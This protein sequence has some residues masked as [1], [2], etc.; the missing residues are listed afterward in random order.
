M[1][2]T[3]TV[4]FWRDDKGFGFIVAKPSQ[5]KLF[6]H[7]RD[8][9][10]QD[11]A[12]QAEQKSSSAPSTIKATNSKA[13]N[14][15][16]TKTVTAKDYRPSVGD[17][18]NFQLDSDKQGRSIA[19]PWQPSAACLAQY[20]ANQ[21]L[22]NQVLDNHSSS[23]GKDNPAAKHSVSANLNAN[24]DIQHTKDISLLFRLGFFVLFIIAILFGTLPYILPILYL[25]A[26]LFTFWLYRAD[27]QAAIARQRDRLPEQ[28]LQLFSLIGGW[29]GAYIAQKKLSHKNSKWLFQREFALIIAANT[30]L[31]IW[32]MSSNGQDFFSQFAFFT[33]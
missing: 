32:L 13:V 11:D 31:V 3:G 24:I 26:S 20:L 14:K 12:L 9:K 7:I 19:A 29:P 33:R 1:Q 6:F 21:A 15:Q 28:S 17:E 23:L 2:L 18:V 22:A 10:L 5:Q 16:H 27:K 30:L 8:L 4:V 25:E